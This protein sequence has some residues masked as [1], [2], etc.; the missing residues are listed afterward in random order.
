RG[1]MSKRI[2]ELFPVKPDA[3]LR[4]YAWSSNN[5]S[6]DYI[7]LIKIGQTTKSDVNKRIRES[8][9]QVQ[10]SYTLHIDELAERED[11]SIFRDS[12]VRQRLIEKGFENP[13]IETSRE[14]MRCSPDD[15]RTA[16]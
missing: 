1:A 10:Q 7:G 4:I 15:V 12:D 11:G 14:W 2:E 8:Q 6:P 5:P 16:V 13:S 9:G 3:R